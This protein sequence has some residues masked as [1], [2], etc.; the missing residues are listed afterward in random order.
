MPSAISG[1]FYSMYWKSFSFDLWQVWPAY[2]GSLSTN[3]QRADNDDHVRATNYKLAGQYLH[4]MLRPDF[5][6]VYA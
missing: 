5:R 1:R 3:F 2:A 4:L 6:R